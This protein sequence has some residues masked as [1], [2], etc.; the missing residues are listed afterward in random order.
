MEL[1]RHIIC[2]HQIGE[3]RRHELHSMKHSQVGGLVQC[4]RICAFDRF[5]GVGW[6]EILSWYLVEWDRLLESVIGKSDSQR[7]CSGIEDTGGP[8]LHWDLGGTAYHFPD[9]QIDYGI[10]GIVDPTIKHTHLLGRFQSAVA[11]P[12]V[13]ELHGSSGYVVYA[14]S[15][16]IINTLWQ[17][18]FEGASIGKPL[19]SALYGVGDSP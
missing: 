10:G 5:L 18:I 1:P 17:D 7:A 6:R 12:F 8:I 9:T 19:D 11:S 15:H 13:R 4:T 3:T 16:E 14:W 2:V